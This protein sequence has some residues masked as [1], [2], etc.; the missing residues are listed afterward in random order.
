[1]F[2]DFLTN[3]KRPVTISNGDR[4][5]LGV[6]IFSQFAIEDTVI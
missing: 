6:H 4:P 2:F 5:F 3:E 1:M